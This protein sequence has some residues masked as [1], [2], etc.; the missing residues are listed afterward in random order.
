M[1]RYEAAAH[2]LLI[3]AGINVVNWRKSMTGVADIETR[4]I[5]CPRP[6]GPVSFA[7]VAHEIY[8]VV[9][10]AQGRQP[11]WVEET[12]AEEFA[13]RALDMFGLPGHER[14][15]ANIAKHLRNTFRKAIQRGVDPLLIE[16]TY[17]VWWR[18]TGYQSVY[19]K[20]GA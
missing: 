6:T 2:G 1:N 8:H 9:V 12:E 10:H 15:A 18:A 19:T 17:P 4:T 16:E 11:R 20:E 5:E 13:L 3:V 14:V 7:I